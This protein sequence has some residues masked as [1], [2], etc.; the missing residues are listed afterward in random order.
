MII[1]INLSLILKYII[2][3]AFFIGLGEL[4]IFFIAVIITLVECFAEL[5][6]CPIRFITWADIRMGIGFGFLLGIIEALFV[7]LTKVSG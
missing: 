5:S 7:L 6:W 2:A 3:G 1:T 4:S